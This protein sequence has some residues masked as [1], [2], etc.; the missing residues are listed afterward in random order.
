[1]AKTRAL[2]GFVPPPEPAPTESLVD[3]L[4]AAY[5]TAPQLQAQRYELRAS[6]DVYAAAL[7]E[8]RPTTQLRVTGSYSRT[9]PGRIT[10]ERRPIEDRLRS[11]LITSNNATAELIVDQPL[12]TGGRAT[13]NR[14][15][16][17]YGISQG[18]AQ[19]RAVEGDLFLQ[20]ITTYADIRRDARVLALREA[21][22]GQLAATLDEVRARREAGELTRTDI[23]QA[24]IQ[25]AAA[26]AALNSTAE[27]LEQDRAA[28][29]ALVGR[30]PGVL[31]PE[32]ALPQLPRSSD[33]AFD[34]AARR[35]PEIAAALAGERVSRAQI[36]AAAAEDAPSLSLRGTA[37]VGGQFLPFYTYN[38]DIGVTG[39]A[40]LTVPLTNGGRIGA[41]IAQ[42][43]NRNA[44][45]RLRIETARREAVR[46]IVTAWN[47][48]A[49]AQRNVAVQQRQLEAAR[50]FDEGTFLEYR[51]GLR[52]TFDVLFAHNSLRDAEI[53]LVASR[54]DLYVAQAAL[55]RQMGLLEARALL[56]G[57][58]LDDPDAH[59]AR[60]R[61]RGA[62]PWD[63]AIRALDAVAV[64]RPAQ[65][66]IAQ[67]PRGVAAAALAPIGRDAPLPGAL[68]RQ[69]PM[70]PVPGTTGAPAP[71]GSIDHP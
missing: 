29:A 1:M 33:E 16:A 52:S 55:L 42:A 18:R 68:L 50:V 65:E 43:K 49:T 66:A 5:R 11:E 2:P 24:E 22:V 53:G 58:V 14:E 39:Q 35:N 61:E 3:A 27:Q 36:A 46:N 69:S 47:A 56:T 30:D 57:T 25:L 45:D 12:Y 38:Q 26:R 59:L 31:A 48:V 54:R 63:P 71:L 23:A 20:V 21:N 51:A 34:L 13:A 64:R 41:R 62:L 7:A 60:A 70:R 28:F 10:E 32:P 67:P 19:L 9:D 44:A 17:A 40:V 4:E 15:V 8:L 37:S 6:D